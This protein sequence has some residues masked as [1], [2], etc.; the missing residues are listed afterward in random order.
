MPTVC[1][2]LQ[3]WYYAQKYASRI[4]QT[5]KTKPKESK[6]Q[7]DPYPTEKSFPGH[8]TKGRLVRSPCFTEKVSGDKV[9]P[10]KIFSK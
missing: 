6:G 2:M 1:L 4:R 7:K 5:L 9:Q 8:F 3:I 10:N